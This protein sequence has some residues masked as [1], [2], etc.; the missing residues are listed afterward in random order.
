MELSLHRCE[1]NDLEQLGTIA[2]E[3]FI[4]SFAH[5]NDPEDFK[6]YMSTAFSD[7]NLR[8]ELLNPD[9][10]FYLVRIGR[11]VVGYFKLNFDTAQTEFQDEKSCEME[12]IYVTSKYQGLGIGEW[13]INQAKAIATGLEKT[14]MWLGVWEENLSAIQFYEKHGFTKF[15]THP[16][17]IGSD[18]QM[19][20]LMRLD[21]VPS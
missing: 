1:I 21:L 6:H 16:Y 11:S 17:Y 3:T 10:A 9:S 15:G 8:G 12:R 7:K 13:M 14:N 18:K 2:R 19:D 4:A 5:L 20:W